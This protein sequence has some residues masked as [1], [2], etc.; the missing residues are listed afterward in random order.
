MHDDDQTRPP[1]PLDLDPSIKCI[2][3][4][5]GGLISVDVANVERLVEVKIASHT[6]GARD[7]RI[8]KVGPSLTRLTLQPPPPDTTTFGD[9]DVEETLTVFSRSADGT[10]HSGWTQFNP[11]DRRV[12]GYECS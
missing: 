3:P 10:T 7:V 8:E 4:A 1:T 12:R 5:R 11:K 6:I 9:G 2:V